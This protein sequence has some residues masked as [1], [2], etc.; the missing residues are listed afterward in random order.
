MHIELVRI[1][2]EIIIAQVAV[3]TSALSEGTGD[4]RDMSEQLVQNLRLGHYDDVRDIRQN[5]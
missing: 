4:M 1:F 5:N 3:L 2:K